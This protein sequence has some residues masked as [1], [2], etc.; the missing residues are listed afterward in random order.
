M[1]HSC[2]DCGQACYCN[3]DIDDCFFEESEEAMKCTH[4]KECDPDNFDE[5]DQDKDYLEDE[6][7][8]PHE[9]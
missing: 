8:P 7:E 9:K 6:K 5:Q 4:W 2:P 1:A 3:G